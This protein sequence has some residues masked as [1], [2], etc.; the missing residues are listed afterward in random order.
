M[1]HFLAA[2]GIGGL[3]IALAGKDTIENLFG[4]IILAV[5]RPIKIGDWVIIKDKEGI[6]EKIG[7]RS[8]TIRT[9]EDS[10]LII[11]NYAFVTSQINNMGERIYRR[12]M[13]TL[14]IDESTTTAKLRS[15]VDA[16]NE[17]VL[18]TPHMRKEGYYIRVN[19]LKPASIKILVYVFFISADWGEELKQREQFIMSIL[20]LAEEIGIKLAPSQKIQFDANY[21]D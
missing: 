17:L 19:D 13:T 15:Y 10:A 2:L 5:E 7:L 18:N 14:E 16:I 11:P 20:D 1:I 21:S 4:S 8:T 9:F 6:V 3:A 12:Y